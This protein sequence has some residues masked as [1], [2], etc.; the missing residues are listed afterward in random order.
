MSTVIR[1]DKE[2]K[3]SIRIVVAHPGKQHS[4]RVAG[5]LKEAG[6]L[7]K[8]VTT[9][10]NKDSSILMRFT[11]LFLGKNN[12]SRALRRKCSQLND[13]DVLQF[14]ELGGL[15]LLALIRIDKS[16]RI[17]KAFNN[18]LSRRFQK[19]LAAFIIQNNV[20]VVISYDT[21][22]TVLFSILKKKAPNVVRIM[23]N[24]HPNRHYLYFSYHE[25][26]DCAGPF[27]DTLSA[28]GYLTDQ[29]Q[30]NYYAEEVK[31][32]DYHIVASTYSQKALE[33]DGIENNKI[34]RIPYG[35][36]EN[37]FLAPTRVFE[38]SCLRALF[39]GEVNQRKGVRQILEAARIINSPE[40][41]F[42]IVGSGTDHCAFLYE[43]YK[44]YV[45]F[46]GYVSYDEVLSQLRNNHVFIFPTMGEGFG[47]VLLEA[48]AAGLIP[49]TTSNCGGADII[50]N[51]VNGFLIDVGDTGAIVDTL[52][53]CKN[54]PS[55]CE[56]MSKNAVRTARRY[57]WEEYSKGIVHMMK[58]IIEVRND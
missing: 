2:F 50:E 49:I 53:W 33:F 38:K 25:H 16:R 23:D 47:L 29:N 10:Y 1:T 14:C 17:S 28:C 37:K 8:Y 54:N 7:Y 57:T 35:V 22:S 55:Q 27:A 6:Y 41:V 18:F 58:D 40:V 36:D 52:M 9:V 30:A 3:D 5:A 31:L 13:N 26:W 11:K 24:A 39:L 4:F 51:G 15:I 42:N 34:Y 32:A 43:P 44:L 12:Y 48:M 20:D 56:E 19:K 46:W 21:N 45:N